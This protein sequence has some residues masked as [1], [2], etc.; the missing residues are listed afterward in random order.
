[1]NAFQDELGPFSAG[2]IIDLCSHKWHGAIILYTVSVS[3]IFEGILTFLK[4][5]LRH[6]FSC[7]Q[8]L[9]TLNK[10]KSKTDDPKSMCVC[11]CLSLASDSSETIEVTIIKLGTVTAS[12]IRM[13]H[14]LIMLTLTFQGH[15]YLNRE[16]KC[17]DYF[18]NCSS[19]PHQISCQ[20]SLSKGL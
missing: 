16:N 8:R 2:F 18:R 7:F 20:D 1:M 9:S 19:N 14:V 5:Y 10:F 3:D 17:F 11:M 15:T 6:K 4:A 13:H 12:E